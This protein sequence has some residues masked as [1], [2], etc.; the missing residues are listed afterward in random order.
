MDGWMC[1]WERGPSC[2][3]KWRRNL[4]ICPQNHRHKLASTAGGAGQLV[5]TPNGRDATLGAPA[6]IR[7]ALVLVLPRNL[8]PIPSISEMKSSSS[9]HFL[10]A[11]DEERRTPVN[12]WPLLT[13]E[14]GV[15]TKAGAI[16][17][18]PATKAEGKGFSSTN[19]DGLLKKRS[20]TSLSAYCP[21]QDAAP[22]YHPDPGRRKRDL[23]SSDNIVGKA[24]K[25]SNRLCQPQA[26]PEIT[27]LSFFLTYSS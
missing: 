21:A 12:F 16:S 18:F 4:Q 9:N 8:P 19:G 11:C 15:T 27:L 6:G 22:F 24:E 5:R 3:Q 13:T 2:C 7:S 25:S 23:W 1:S 10:G 14:R 26:L 17:H 20:S